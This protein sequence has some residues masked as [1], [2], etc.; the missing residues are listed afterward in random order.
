M[1]DSS[2]G[3]QLFWPTPYGSG[4]RRKW[5][6]I[7]KNVEKKR[8]SAASWMIPNVSGSKGKIDQLSCWRFLCSYQR[9]AKSGVDFLSFDDE[10][11]GILL[12]NVV[13]WTFLTPF[14]YSRWFNPH[15]RTSPD[16]PCL[17]H[18]WSFCRRLKAL[19][20][21]ARHRTSIFLVM[22]SFPE[23]LPF[24]DCHWIP[25]FSGTAF[26]PFFRTFRTSQKPSSVI[27]HGVLEA[28]DHWKFG[29]F[30]S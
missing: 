8:L 30:P 6:I 17:T 28:M 4:D 20:W 7:Q 18:V 12:W 14:L 27:K 13:H 24:G 15:S 9:P 26:S 5:R 1:A 22:G 19:V 16:L 3:K 10:Y 2:W 11:P 25:S 23:S 29:D 21:C